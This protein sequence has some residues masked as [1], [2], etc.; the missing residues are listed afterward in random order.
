VLDEPTND[1]DMETLDLLQEMLGDYDGTALLVSHDRDFLDRTVTAVIAAE[2][3]GKWIVYAGGYSDMIAQRKGQKQGQESKPATPKSNAKKADS[4]RSEPV[5][6]KKS[7]PDKTKTLSFTDKHH[8]KTLPARMDKFHKAIDASNA[9]LAKPGLFERDRAA[10]E[11]AAQ[12]L[13]ET[14]TALEAAGEQWLALE[15]KREESEGT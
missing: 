9:L 14:V 10:F 3:N 5:E 6:I 1:L 15:L 8:L 4:S 11:A 2:G 12:K 13:R 7:P